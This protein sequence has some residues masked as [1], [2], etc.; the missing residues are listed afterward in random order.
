[1]VGVVVASGG[2]VAVVSCSSSDAAGTPGVDAGAD[3]T[4]DVATGDDAAADAPSE[5][6][7]GGGAGDLGPLAAY[8]AQYAAATCD[9]R[10][11]CSGNADPA[12]LADTTA[13]CRMYARAQ[14][15][16]ALEAGVVAFDPAK[17]ATCFAT[18]FDDFCQPESFASLEACRG[19][20]TGTVPLGSPCLRVYLF[21]DVD[22]CKD[23][24]CSAGEE[25]GACTPGTC[26]PFLDAGATC[27]DDAGTS[28][29][30][31]C[32]P[33]FQCV[34]GAC[35]A[36][37]KP[38]DPCTSAGQLCRP[39]WP[40]LDCAP[41]ADGGLACDFARPGGGL[42]DDHGNGVDEVCR[43]QT[44][45]GDGGCSDT[46]ADGGVICGST[47]PPCPSGTACQ[48]NGA[49][50]MSCQP[51]RAAHA[52]C[53]PGD[54]CADGFTCALAADGGA[55]TC[56]ALP[57]VGAPCEGACASGATCSRF[58]DAGAC[59]AVVAQGGACRG[60]GDDACAPGLTCSAASRTCVPFAA[61][62]AACVADG[63]CEKGLYCD[64]AAKVCRAWKRHGQPCARDGECAY[65][66]G[67]VTS[68]CSSAC[69]VP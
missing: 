54:V 44:C 65:A 4:A 34:G 18:P 69:T 12:C 7:D 28:I 23:G 68:A 37:G 30:P 22:E 25:I 27:T 61:F 51:P 21:G 8:C 49:D 24:R 3:G 64:D 29:E 56:A 55:G 66:Q 46:L 33:G 45:G 10:A 26:A 14:I 2:I 35:A 60:P 58:D 62:G 59:A 52:A 57:G 39:T 31:G 19:V 43:S 53:A 6:G 15:A 38:G 48:P 41:F 17:A 42:C 20:F 16:E 5:A 67:C 13:A 63:D 9:R 47:T 40:V 1:L 50:P 32:A 11:Y 36:D